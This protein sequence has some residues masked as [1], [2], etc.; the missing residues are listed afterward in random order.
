[1]WTSD[2]HAEGLYWPGG[3]QRNGARV[4]GCEALS[5]FPLDTDVSRGHP[6]R[7][8]QYDTV[9]V[10]ALV[11]VLICCRRL[12]LSIA[13]GS[14]GGWTEVRMSDLAL[15]VRGWRSPS[16]WGTRLPV[17]GHRS[18]RASRR[19]RRHCGA[20]GVGKGR[21]STSSAPRSAHSRSRIID[22]VDAFAHSPAQLD[23]LRN[24]QM[25]LCSFLTSFTRTPCRTSD[26]A[27]IGGSP[28]EARDRAECSAW[29]WRLE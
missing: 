10:V 3:H 25:A 8:G 29:V 16:R 27:L 11:A 14:P 5:E 15:S 20:V 21:S 4:G 24:R 6:A 19:T 17:C 7:C 22:N 18:G 1:M 9:A 2:L 28:L 23:T 12:T 26:P 13:A